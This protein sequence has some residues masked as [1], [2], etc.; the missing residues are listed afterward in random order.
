MTIWT[1]SNTSHKC[2]NNSELVVSEGLDAPKISVI[3]TGLNRS[4]ELEKLFHSILNQKIKPYEVI[5]VDGGSIDN[6]IEIAK[7]YNVKVIVNNE[8]NT[9][10]SGRNT[11]LHASSGDFVLFLDSDCILSPGFLEKCH[12]IARNLPENVAGFGAGYRYLDLD[13][14]EK[15]AKILIDALTCTLVNGGSSQFKLWNKRKFVDRLPG[16]NCCYRKNVLLKFG[17]F[18]NKL[19]YCEEVELGSKLRKQGFCLLYIPELVVFHKPFLTARKT[20]KK[21]TIYGYWRGWYFLKEAFSFPHL[22]MFIFIVGLILSCL[23]HYSALPIL[24]S[25]TTYILSMLTNII[26]EKHSFNFP[27]VLCAGI[28]IHLCY[29]GSFFVGLIHRLAHIFMTNVRKFT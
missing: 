4:E 11:G 21:I 25:F 23:V 8:A 2:I 24:I 16:G 6:S 27:I 1:L 22:L 17:G 13:Y 7:K 5:Y 18:N 15:F 26:I 3:V 9:P 20:L 29:L 10:A 12:E 28:T 19:N 14:S